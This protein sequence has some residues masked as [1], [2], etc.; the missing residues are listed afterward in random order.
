MDFKSKATAKLTDTVGKTFDRCMDFYKRVLTTHNRC[1][2]SVA[3]RL[4]EFAGQQEHLKYLHDRLQED[5]LNIQQ[6]KC[7]NEKIVKGLFAQAAVNNF[8]LEDHLRVTP[9]KVAE[10]RSQLAVLEVSVIILEPME[11]RTIAIDAASWNKFVDGLVEP[12]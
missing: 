9:H 3:K 8:L 6:I 1:Q 4:Q 7:L 5:D 2:T 11:F 10:I 12:T